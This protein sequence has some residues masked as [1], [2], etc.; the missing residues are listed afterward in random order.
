MRFDNFTGPAW[1][2]EDPKVVPVPCVTAHFARQRGGAK[3]LSRTQF[4]IVLSWAST[5]HKA[6]GASY[7]RC[8]VAMS[9]QSEARPMERHHDPCEYPVPFLLPS[10]SH[11]PPISPTSPSPISPP[12][13][14]WEVNFHHHH[15]RKN[16]PNVFLWRK[17]LLVVCPC[18]RRVEVAPRERSHSRHQHLRNVIF[19]HLQQCLVLS[20]SSLN[21][22]YLSS[23]HTWGR[24]MSM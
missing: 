5:I 10:S 15:G 18:P 2:P 16:N 17:M 14:L 23:T 9:C 21:F 22:R 20:T 19:M 24:T 1:D 8:V 7:D 13:P 6:Q 4:P 3:T 12:S 11:L